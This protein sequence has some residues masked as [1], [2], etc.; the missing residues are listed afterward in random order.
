MYVI[1]HDNRKSAKRPLHCLSIWKLISSLSFLFS[2]IY[3]KKSSIFCKN[4]WFSD[5]FLYLENVLPLFRYFCRLF[6]DTS[7]GNHAAHHGGRI[8]IGV[9]A[10][11]GSGIQDAVAS[12]LH[13]VSQ[14][15][16]VDEA[17]AMYRRCLAFAAAQEPS[18]FRAELAGL[19]EQLRLLAE[20]ERFSAR[21][22]F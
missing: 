20:M 9:P 4:R 8:D 18:E 6:V 22:I 10:Y 12:Y 16:A 19:R 15:N 5:H 2:H 3:E 14:H 7:G 17:E 1:I 21:N 11:D 13:M